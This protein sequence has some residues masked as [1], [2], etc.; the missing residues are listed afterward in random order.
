[1]VGNSG[2][3]LRV[4]PALIVVIS[5]ALGE[6]AELVAQAA[7][8]Q[9][10][11]HPVEVRRFPHVTTEQDF[12]Q[13]M[14]GLKQM[15][16]AV[17]YTIILPELRQA[18][19]G[20]LQASSVPY[21]DV[22]G[23]VLDGLAGALAAAPSRQ[24]GLVHRLDARYFRRVEAVEFAVRYDDGKDPAGILRAEVVLLGVSRTSKTPTSMYLAHR[25]IKVA[26]VPLV[27][28]ADLPDEIF[29]VS[30]RKIMGLTI[31]PEILLQIR[32]ERLKSLGLGSGSR[33]A[34][35]GRIIEELEYADHVY[36]R[37]GCTVIDVSQKAVEET[38]SRILELVGR[39]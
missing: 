16:A 3:D 27:P 32:T 23:P 18:I 12:L 28:E 35:L 2:A 1:M 37:L 34:D 13:V 8:S 31:N 29:Q 33:Y 26:N 25:Q 38:A 7:A 15:P 14:A 10:P 5:D 21:V 19:A 30:P 39:T 17:V 6:T 24:P 4:R 22:M 20:H 9:F 36:R 11:G